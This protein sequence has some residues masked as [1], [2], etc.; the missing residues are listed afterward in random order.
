MSKKVRLIGSKPLSRIMDSGYKHEYLPFCALRN[1][2]SA[3][4]I[5]S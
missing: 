1:L 3:Q 4:I 5:R 2:I